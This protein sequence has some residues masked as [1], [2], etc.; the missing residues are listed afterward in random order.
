MYH[1]ELSDG[2]NHNTIH[3]QQFESYYEKNVNWINMI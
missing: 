3:K 1:I 2:V